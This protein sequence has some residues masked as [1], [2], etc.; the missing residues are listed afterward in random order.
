[1]KKYIFGFTTLFWICVPTFLFADVHPKAGVSLHMRKDR[2]PL[3]TTDLIVQVDVRFD[4]TNEIDPQVEPLYYILHIS[5]A[6]SVV[7]PQ[8]KGAIPYRDFRVSV[9]GWK[10]KELDSG[11]EA[12][13]IN[14]EYFNNF[15]IDEKRVLH[16]SLL[17]GSVGTELPWWKKDGEHDIYIKG[18][19]DAFGYRMVDHIKDLEGHGDLYIGKVGAEAGLTYYPLAAFPVRTA[20]GADIDASIHLGGLSPLDWS[21]YSDR[22]YYVKAT[23]D[24]RQWGHK[25]HFYVEGDQLKSTDNFVQSVAHGEQLMSGLLVFF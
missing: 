23:A 21:R 25:F 6:G 3:E 16:V 18:F 13:A 4:K 15:V 7:N 5:A 14:F 1:M 12:E 8:G 17:Q 11:I 19:I 10:S 9:F 24:W 22:R 20:I 2:K